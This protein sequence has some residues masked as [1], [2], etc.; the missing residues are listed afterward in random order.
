MS[1]YSHSAS[2]TRLAGFADISQFIGAT[3]QRQPQHIALDDGQHAVTYAQ[4]DRRCN[5]AAHGLRELG[6]QAGDRIAVLAEN[7]LE[8]LELAVAAAR[9]G[10]I[11]CALNWRFS[12]DEI[13]H[14]IAL[15][16]PSLIF[17][18]AR[19]LSLLNL[20]PNNALDISALDHVH[21]TAQR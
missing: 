19:H 2:P 6:I 4:F 8:Y 10:A 9:T 11:L 13:A 14:C 18:S 20:A 21:R 1:D 15:T 5:Q 3:A 12:Q 17:V 16:S 7:R